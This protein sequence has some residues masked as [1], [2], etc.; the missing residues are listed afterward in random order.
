MNVA[1]TLHH[2]E[3]NIWVSPC[4]LTDLLFRFD[5]YS[6]MEWTALWEF[7]FLSTDYRESLNS[8]AADIYGEALTVAKA[9]FNAP[10][11]P[12]EAAAYG[13]GNRI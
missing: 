10:S 3:V 12:A 7:L 1:L 11:E 8:S 9:A 4:V 6:Q 13:D 2:T 5:T